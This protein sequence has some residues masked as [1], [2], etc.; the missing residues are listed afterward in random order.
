MKRLILAAAIVAAA[1]PALPQAL[2]SL[3]S[4]RVGY[5]TRKNTVKP[6]G[7]LKAQ[8]DALDQQ[9]AEA[10]R[11]GRTGELR[12]L[13]AKGIVLLS[14]REWTDA[15]DYNASLVIRTDRVV[16][17]SSQPYTARLEQLYQ[18]SIALEHALSAH[19]VLRT[20]PIVRPG[21]PAQPGGLVKDLGTFAGVSRDLRESPFAMELDL[22]DIADGTYALTVDVMNDAATLGT[23]MLTVALEKGLDAQIRRLAAAADS[24]PDDLRA[25]IL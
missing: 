9:I 18:P 12:R 7:A 22:R 19:A 13:F 8:I 21:Q 6:E 25:E 14:G 4:V 23:A 5:T 10:T 16:A 1:S 20:R 2:T 17:D 24:A 15:A 11:L 3:A